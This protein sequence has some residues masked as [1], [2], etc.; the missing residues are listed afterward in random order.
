MIAQSES[1]RTILA[2]KALDGTGRDHWQQA[3]AKVTV[4]DVEKALGCQ[5]GSYTPRKLLALV[6]PAA[7]KFLEPMARIAHKLTVQRFGKT[8]QLYAPLYLS[9]Y[10][11][12]SCRYCAYNIASPA[13]RTR[14]TIP[15]ALA[16]ARIIRGEGLRHI[17]LVSGED[18][19]HITPDY[20][21]EL[22]AK[23]RQHFCSI[24][25]E[26]YP[27]TARQYGA[28]YQA[29]IDGVTLYQETYDRP[30]YAFWHPA[31]PKTDYD[32]RLI[33]HDLTAAA[34]IRR[35]GIGALL[36]LADW[37]FETLSLAEHAAYLIRHYWKSQVS[38]SLPRLRPARNA[39]IESQYLLSDKQ[40]VQMLLALRLCFADAGI[41]LSTRERP[42]LR[43]SLIP[44]GVTQLSAGSRTNPGGYSKC[45][46]SLEQFDI[47]DHRS[48]AQVA[49]A[50][51]AQG[52]QVIWKDWDTAFCSQ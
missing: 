48:P 15:Q 25:V 3:L 44:L 6:S 33:T 27:M 50:V 12:N 31:G 19:D 16:E 8:V 22:A 28:L 49:A 2:Q 13:Y 14:L 42:Q 51:E 10:C 43:D 30:A 45:T 40:L 52:F 5:P 23:L 20:L 17:L 41:T 47:A 1:I 37:R 29:G 32:Q 26:V 39:A 46:T 34:G 18:R 24:S 36:G 21:A 11:L 9:N 35:L 38:F 4:R 7:G